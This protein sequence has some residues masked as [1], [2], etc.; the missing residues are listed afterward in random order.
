LSG[1]P[2]PR[3]GGAATNKKVARACLL[4]LIILNS[5]FFILAVEHKYFNPPGF[6]ENITL[7]SLV[8][9]IEV[10]IIRQK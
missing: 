3:S 6:K 4:L 1:R 10:L 2:V 9:R 7:I 8:A 5:H